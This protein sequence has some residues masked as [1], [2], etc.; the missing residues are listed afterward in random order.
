VDDL[1]TFIRFDG[2]VILFYKYPH[3]RRAYIVRN[4]EE[5]R[6]YPSITLPN[7]KQKV[8]VI[9]RARGRR[10]DILRNVYWNLEQLNGRKVYAYD[11]FF[12][13]KVGCLLDNYHSLKS[14]A[15]KG[16]L[17]LLNDTMGVTE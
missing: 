17:M 3:H 12:W 13:Q 14:A 8:G 6:N 15:N 4:I 1:G 10:V 11:T 2:V 9:Y 7:V 16:N 5:L